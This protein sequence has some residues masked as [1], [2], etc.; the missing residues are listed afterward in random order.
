MPEDRTRLR[1][2]I[3]F[4]IAFVA[5]AAVLIGMTVGLL[6]NWTEMPWGGRLT[7]LAFIWITG[8]GIVVTIRKRIARETGKQPAAQRRARSYLSRED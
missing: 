7:F 1:S 8:F 2:W 3:E 4:A 6:L 5:F